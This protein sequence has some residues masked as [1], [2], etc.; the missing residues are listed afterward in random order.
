MLRWRVSAEKNGTAENAED[1][2]GAR[3]FFCVFCVFCGLNRLRRGASE[4]D[5]REIGGDQAAD[6][7]A[8]DV[9]VEAALAAAEVGVLVANL[10]AE[11]APLGG[12]AQAPVAARA[13]VL[14]PAVAGQRLQ[15]H[16][17]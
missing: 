3:F 7:G 10:K 1:A 9:G 2:E 4:E 8:A 6:G 17:L 16:R 13:A 12:R 14:G 5:Q 15:G 11:P